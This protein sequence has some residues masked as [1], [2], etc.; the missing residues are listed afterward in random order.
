MTLDCVGF[1]TVHLLLPD[2]RAPMG[3][4]VLVDGLQDEA[5]LRQRARN[6]AL[7]NAGGIAHSVEMLAELGLVQKASVQPRSTGRP[8]CSSCTS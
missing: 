5:A 7:T 1:P 8:A 6:I 4:P 2:T 3:V